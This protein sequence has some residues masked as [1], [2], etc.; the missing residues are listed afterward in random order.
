MPL[1][2]P[3]P[4]I[5]AI[6]KH[7]SD[8]CFDALQ[9]NIRITLE[10]LASPADLFNF[11][12]SGALVDATKSVLSGGLDAFHDDFVKETAIRA[13]GSAIEGVGALYPDL[14]ENINKSLNTVFNIINFAYLAQNNMIL[15]MMKIVARNI[16]NQIESKESRIDKLKDLLTQLYNIMLTARNGDPIYD[17]YLAQLKAAL[18]ELISARANVQ[19][20]K[21]T[22]QSSNIYL[23]QRYDTAKSQVSS[24]LSKVRPT[25]TN[26]LISPFLQDGGEVSTDG[27]LGGAVAGAAEAATRPY[28]QAG[29]FLLDTAG[30]PNSKEQFENLMQIPAITGE[31]IN[32]MRDYA[33]TV[34]SINGMLSAFYVGIAGLETAFYDSL[35]KYA[36]EHLQ[37]ILND[38][39]SVQR[40]MGAVLNVRSPNPTKVMTKAFEW[41]IKL[42]QTLSLMKILPSAALSKANIAAGEIGMYE[43]TIALLKK[44]DNVSADG[45]TLFAED[46]KENVGLLEQQLL[47][48]LLRANAQM[49]TLTIQDSVLALNK[50]L[51]TR[52]AITKNR[53]T[54]IKTILQAFVDYPLAYET[55]LAKAIEGANAILK[56]AGLNRAADLLAT[57]DLSAF[58]EMNAKTASYVGAALNAMAFLKDCFDTEEERAKHNGIQSE[59]ESD[60]DLLNIQV[61]FNLDL[62]FFQNLEECLRVEGLVKMFDIEEYL[63]GLAESAGLGKAFDAIN[64]VVRF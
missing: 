4:D 27:T 53:D 42:S 29:A 31:I 16:I 39:D 41:T 14:Y 43:N 49:V 61:G 7:F 56:K 2:I 55:E 62:R 51:I 48:L 19:L 22:L 63:C 38:M 8:K 34:S 58:F 45:A 54:Q 28:A 12:I 3:I 36:Q 59:L 32:T 17:E 20:V 46:A 44:L 11:E 50:T 21:S 30:V 26:P 15:F 23:S 57:G 25:N 40:S 47:P 52:M 24:A 64:D 13:A 18:A 35:S 37:R 60:M 5:G 33:G 6:S 9:E 1:G 10:K